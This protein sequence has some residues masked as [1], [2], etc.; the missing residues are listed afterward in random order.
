MGG[1]EAVAAV[2]AASG[3]ES[4]VSDVHGRDPARAWRSNRDRRN[5]TRA[6]S[7]DDPSSMAS[8]M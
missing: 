2:I 8:D 4:S 5:E 1:L 3:N 6:A 7:H